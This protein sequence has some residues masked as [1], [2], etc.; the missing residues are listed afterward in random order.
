MD[1]SNALCFLSTLRRSHSQ[2]V[3]KSCTKADVFGTFEEYLST[4]PVQVGRTN[5]RT[6]RLCGF[7]FGTC[8]PHG[9]HGRIAKYAGNRL[10][11]DAR[12][13][14]SPWQ[15]RGWQAPKKNPENPKT[16]TLKP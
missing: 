11:P 8:H 3:V 4:T 15:P 5:T 14:I 16:N 9:S 13:G 12:L 7:F 1:Q 2:M 10:K 6:K